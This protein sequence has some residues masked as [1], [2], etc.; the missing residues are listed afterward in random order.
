MVVRSQMPNNGKLD[1]SSAMQSK[2]EQSRRVKLMN[3]TEPS[4]GPGLDWFGLPWTVF[5][6]IR[7][8]ERVKFL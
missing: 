8:S 3:G 6:E 2:V 7:S 1:Q 4:R 5:R